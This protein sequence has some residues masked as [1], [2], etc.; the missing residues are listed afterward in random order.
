M[1]Y[2]F[3]INQICENGNCGENIN[4]IIETYLG[5]E[6]GVKGHIS[7]SHDPENHKIWLLLYDTNGKHESEHLGKILIQDSNT[8]KK[9]LG[10]TPLL[11]ELKDLF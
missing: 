3:T 4:N 11:S 1:L 6:I 8:S 9:W 2:K 5:S 10:K 7:I